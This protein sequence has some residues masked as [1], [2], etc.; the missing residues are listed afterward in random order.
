[1]STV[2]ARAVAGRQKEGKN[3]EVVNNAAA[4]VDSNA[5]QLCTAKE[6]AHAPRA[7]AVGRKRAHPSSSSAPSASVRLVKPRRATSPRPVVVP[8]ALSETFTRLVDLQR[9]CVAWER[10]VPS[11]W[12]LQVRL[13]RNHRRLPDERYSN[14]FRCFGHRNN[15]ASYARSIA[16]DNVKKG[17]RLQAE[18]QRGWILN[19]EMQTIYNAHP[20]LLGWHLERAH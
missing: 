5:A 1:M 12:L 2:A 11:R 13:P 7:A 16:R 14:E 15:A 10:E 6:G 19:R 8:P 17:G 4:A 9:A 3:A 18:A 20:Q